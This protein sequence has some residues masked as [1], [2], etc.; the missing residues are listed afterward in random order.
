MTPGA[1][2]GDGHEHGEKFSHSKSQDGHSDGRCFAQGQEVAGYYV[3]A[4]D[5]GDLFQELRTCGDARFFYAVEIA[6]DAGM[7]GGKVA[8]CSATNLEMAVWYPAAVREKDR[9]RTGLKSW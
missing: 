6:V 9:E 1:D 5:P 2:G 8:V 4:A 3:Y 7:D